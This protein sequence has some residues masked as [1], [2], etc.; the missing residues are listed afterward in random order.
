MFAVITADKIIINEITNVIPINCA[1]N[2]GIVGVG[3]DI[4]EGVADCV[5]VGVGFRV[6]VGVGVG[7]RVGVGVGF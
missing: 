2:S 3:V 1:G 7:F 5:I 4:T 6:G